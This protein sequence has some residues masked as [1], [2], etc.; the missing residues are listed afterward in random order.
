[1]LRASC[2]QA[3]RFACFAAASDPSPGDAGAGADGAAG[4]LGAA[5]T[6][7]VGTAAEAMANPSASAK[8]QVE[9]PV[10]CETRIKYPRKRWQPDDWYRDENNYA[11]NLDQWSADE[12]SLT[13][14]E[15]LTSKRQVAA[16]VRGS[17]A[18]LG[19]PQRLGQRLHEKVL[20]M[21]SLA[22]AHCKLAAQ[23]AHAGRAVDGNLLAYRHVQSHM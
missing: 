10:A 19:F 13:L 15:F 2:R 23:R 3:V 12:A 18:S 22:E 17:A 6:A 5:C 8:T 16:L 20:G 21:V 9:R 4:V 11:R 1:L 7:V 14:C